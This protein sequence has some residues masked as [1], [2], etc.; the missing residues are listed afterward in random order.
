MAYVTIDGETIELD[1]NG[2]KDGTLNGKFNF[3]LN[4]SYIKQ[5]KA[6]LPNDYYFG[7]D[8]KIYR[9]QEGENWDIKGYRSFFKCSDNTSGAKAI[10]NGADFGEDSGTTAID[11]VTADNGNVISANAVIYDLNGR[12]VKTNTEG[13]KDL[14]KG[15]YIVNGKKVTVK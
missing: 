7:G 2:K 12:I 6:L 13:L 8:G 3:T 10:L 4:A 1:K 14:V 5:E 11:H 15:V 9:T